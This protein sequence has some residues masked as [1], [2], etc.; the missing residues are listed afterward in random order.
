MFRQCL[1]DFPADSMKKTGLY[2][3]VYGFSG[4]GDSIDVV[5][6]LDIHKYLMKK[7]DIR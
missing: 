3:Y 2:R 4:A 1:K 5:D 7:Y 6:I